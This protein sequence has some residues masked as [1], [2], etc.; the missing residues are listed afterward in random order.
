MAQTGSEDEV[1]EALQL[2]SGLQS[3]MISSYGGTQ[4][5]NWIVSLI[6]LRKLSL[7]ECQN[8]TLLPPIGRLSS[9]VMLY[10]D[11][12]HNLKSLRLEFLGAT[13]NVNDRIS[14]DSKDRSLALQSA[15]NIAFPKLK[16]LKISNMRSWEEW[17]MIRAEGEDM[18]IMPSL[19]CTTSSS[20]RDNT[21]NKVAYPELSAHTTVIPEAN[22]GALDQYIP[23]PKAQTTQM[24]NISG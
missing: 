15:E 19:L 24:N 1:I 13:T 23:H 9:L 8:R 20:L 3:L 5:P 10:I 21:N 14:S 2:H 7:Q 17:N 16:K 22:W 12:L 11:G 4:F 6:N 18:K